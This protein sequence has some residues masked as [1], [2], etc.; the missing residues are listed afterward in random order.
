MSSTLLCRASGGLWF[1]YCTREPLQGPLTPLSV[2]HRAPTP[3]ALAEENSHLIKSHTR[4]YRLPFISPIFFFCQ[5]LSLWS[6]NAITSLLCSSPC[7][8][9]RKSP[10]VSPRRLSDI[11]PQ[12][13]QLKYL[14]VDEA[15]KEDLKSSRS[16]EDINSASIEER[17]LRITGYYGYQPWNAS[18]KSESICTHGCCELLWNVSRSCPHNQAVSHCYTYHTNT[19]VLKKVL[20]SITWCLIW[21]DSL[22]YV[23]GW[24][25][26]SIWEYK[27]DY[28]SLF[29]IL[30]SHTVVLPIEAHFVAF[31]FEVSLL[32]HIMDLVYIHPVPPHPSH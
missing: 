29:V 2:E 3:P 22:V 26:Y 12:L 9:M 18:G 23:G 32:N 15:I 21:F 16:V 5:A 30:M 4:F 19:Q 17:I 14:V 20:W 31:G 27:V 13:R 8:G 11:S 28:F 7:S 24:V 1:L 25:K 6:C 10:D